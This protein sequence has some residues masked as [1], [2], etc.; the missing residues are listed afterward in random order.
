MTYKHRHIYNSIELHIDK[1]EYTIITGARQ[2]GKTTLLREFYKELKR[3]DKVVHFLSFENVEVLKAVNEH[4]ENLFKFINRPVNPLET[5]DKVTDRIF[6]LIDEVQ[7]VN[8][9]SGFLKYLFDTYLDNLKIIATGSSAFYIDS[10]FRDSLAGRKK[11][12]Q[13]FSLNFLEYLEFLERKDLSDEIHEIKNRKE[14][15]S[16]KLREIY[17]YFDLFLVYGGYPAVVLELI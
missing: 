15:I 2:V 12:F 10:K 14:Y 4:P 5:E 11:I 13:L 9:P 17:E 1:K 7:Y 6:L 3:K 8:D 16:L